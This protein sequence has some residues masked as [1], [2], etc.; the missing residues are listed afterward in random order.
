VRGDLSQGKGSTIKN[1]KEV[2]QNV[3]RGYNNTFFGNENFY[4][5]EAWLIRT[6]KSDVVK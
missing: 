4:D 2:G 1:R 5:K 6:K 3:V